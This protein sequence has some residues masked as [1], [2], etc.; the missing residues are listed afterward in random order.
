MNKNYTISVFETIK[1]INCIIFEHPV[2]ML[3]QQAEGLL[4]KKKTQQSHNTHKTQYT[5]HNDSISTRHLHF[6]IHTHKQRFPGL[7]KV[8]L[9]LLKLMHMYYVQ[10]SA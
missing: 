9:S 2:K 6:Y 8:A 7:G 4:L 3:A 10:E 5:Y 1:L